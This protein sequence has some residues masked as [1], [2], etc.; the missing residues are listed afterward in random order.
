MATLQPL[1]GSADLTSYFSNYT[2]T[3]VN[4]LTA[5]RIP[6]RHGTIVESPTIDQKIITL[7]GTIHGSDHEDA[8]SKVSAL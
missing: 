1:F 2:E 8:R 7:T 3:I 4:R 5:V 6:Q